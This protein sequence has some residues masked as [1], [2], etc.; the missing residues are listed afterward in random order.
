MRA[1]LINA[2]KRKVEEIQLI[3][4]HE[5]IRRILKTPSFSES[6]LWDN[7]VILYSSDCL[8]NVTA[9]GI[10]IIANSL[11]IPGCSVL[12][13]GNETSLYSADESIEDIKK[14]VKFI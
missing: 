7:L 1:I 3:N 9:S 10:A 8:M 12:L 2:T 4:F 14:I 6:F 13:H 11:Y 5:D